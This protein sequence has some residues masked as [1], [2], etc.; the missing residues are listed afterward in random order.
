MQRRIPLISYLIAGFIMVAGIGFANPPT[1]ADVKTWVKI[2]SVQHDVRAEN[3]C[4]VFHQ[5]YP[6]DAEEACGLISEL[7][8]KGPASNKRYRI[9]LNA[10]KALLGHFNG[11]CI[12]DNESHRALMEE[13]TRLAFE[14]DD[15]QLIADA[16]QWY[17]Q[18]LDPIHDIGK[19]SFYAISA[20]DMQDQ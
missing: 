2:L 17:V 11:D 3:F 13:A 1:E 12:S 20:A 7:E 6:M 10:I 14:L 18:I 8:R 15:P 16:C 9:R 5:L 19:Y 4:T